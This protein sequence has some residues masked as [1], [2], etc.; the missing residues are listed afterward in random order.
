MIGIAAF[1]GIPRL[2]AEPRSH[3]HGRWPIRQ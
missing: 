3:D 2:Q 1:G